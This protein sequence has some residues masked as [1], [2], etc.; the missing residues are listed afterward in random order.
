[1]L[2]RRFEDEVDEEGWWA[3]CLWWYWWLRSPG[4]LW[5]GSEVGKRIPWRVF[6]KKN[7]MKIEQ[8]VLISVFRFKDLTQEQTVICEDKNRIFPE[9]I[10]E[11]LV[12]VNKRLFSRQS[13]GKRANGHAKTCKGNPIKIVIL[14]CV[15]FC[16]AIVFILRN[17]HLRFPGKFCATGKS[18]L[19]ISSSKSW[20]CR[21]SQSHK[22]K[23]PRIDRLPFSRR[24]SKNSRSLDFPETSWL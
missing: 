16:N 5:F 23:N 21:D 22:N 1:M 9:R 18:L 10:N 8:E 12:F 20:W 13:N 2:C 11:L 15:N 17:R 14:S 4:V 6:R 24:T 7:E 19:S 3:C